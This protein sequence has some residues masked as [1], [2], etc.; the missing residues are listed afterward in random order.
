LSAIEGDYAYATVPELSSA[1]DA[2]KVSAVALAE[3]AINRI[4]RL[5]TS[6]NAV[7]VRD[8][9]RALA[10]ARAADA[11]RS[12]GERGP[13]LG[14]P[15]T[16]KESFNVAGL[17][18]TFGFSRFE[19]FVPE[20][21]ALA[22]TRLRAAGAVLLGKTNVPVALGDF[23]SYNSIYGTTN[24]P[25][26]LERTP[27]GSSG[28]S[29]AALA[30]GFGSVSL[31]SDIAGSLRVPGHFC[32]VYAHK[33][34]YGLVPT[35]GHLAPPAA[36]LNYFRDLSVIGPMARSA[37][38]LMLLLDLLAEPD[39]RDLGLAH[40][41]ALRP[42]RHDD[43]ASYR[44]LVI[45]TH[46]LVAT[47]DE[48]RQSV[49]RIA[50]TLKSAGAKVRRESPLLP[51]LVNAARVYMRLVMATV[52]G[53]FPDELYHEMQSAA[54]RFDPGDRSLAAERARGCVLTY[55]AWVAADAARARLR[56]QWRML[57]GE[58]DVVV[59]PPA[60]TVAFRHDHSADQWARHL[61]VD[62]AD[63]DYSDQAVWPGMATAP[64]LPATVI[65][66]GTTAQGLP[67]GVQL[68]GPLYEDRTPIRL[69]ELL[70]RTLG[71]FRAPN[72]G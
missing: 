45:D 54:A 28:G 53:A 17:P 6:I 41:L 2:G 63:V 24:N 57:F 67:V 22:V 23:Q 9:D 72:I 43:L 36:P 26:D 27:G 66:N 30:A 13:L 4:E 10:A 51:D 47:S 55:R 44:V 33:P 18:T 16:V 35:R 19:D 56:E 58:F 69:A 60:P 32:G 65:P 61:S 70:E 62:G 14:V 40:A 50:R 25:W 39:D 34:S 37:N 15:A 46:P 11:A 31:G 7:P 1:L 20:S 8:F 49:D 59:C 48:V 3:A 64:G 21:D 68:I 71:G 29:A 42:A 5:D 52:A 38:D 12:R